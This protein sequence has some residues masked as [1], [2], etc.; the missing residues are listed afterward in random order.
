MISTRGHPRFEARVIYRE[1]LWQ[2]SGPAAVE[3][4]VINSE[5]TI[6]LPINP[7]LPS[8]ILVLAMVDWSF[9]NQPSTYQ[10]LFSASKSN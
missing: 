6:N 2:R 10:Y 4:P 9:L 5:P 3:L 1:K 8:M 7:G